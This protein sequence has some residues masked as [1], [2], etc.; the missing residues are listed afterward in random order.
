MRATNEQPAHHHRGGETLNLR[1]MMIRE[2]HRL[3]A[4]DELRADRR[5]LG[6]MLAE[7]DEILRLV[8]QRRQ[9]RADDSGYE[10]WLSVEDRY[11]EDRP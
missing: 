5:K 9:G 2:Y 3:R 7:L 6:E 4:A 11:Q 1:A 10:G 8:E